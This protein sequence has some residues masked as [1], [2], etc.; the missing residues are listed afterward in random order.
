MDPAA[1]AFDPA[2]FLRGLDALHAGGDGPDAVERYLGDALAAAGDDPAARLQILNEAM[3]HHRAVSRHDDALREAAEALALVDRLGLAGTEAHATTLVNAATAHRAAGRQEEAL[4]LYADARAAAARAYPAGDRRLAAL[5]N[6]LALALGETGD[7]AGARDELAAALAILESA[8]VDPG[9]DLDIAAA[10]SNLAL[11]C[12]A[13]GLEDEAR[14]HTR[15]ALAIV[16]AGGHREDPHAAAMLA[17]HAQA[18]LLGGHPAEAVDLYAEA[19]AIVA[20]AYGEGSDAHAI[21]ADNLAAARRALAAAGP[22]ANGSPEAAPAAAS[23]PPEATPAALTGM[24]LARELWEDHVRPMLAERYP[25]HRGRIAA[26][27]VGHGSECYG[28]DDA[29][30][31][32]HDFGPGLC[33]WLT[34]AD[35]AEIGAALQADY[36]ALPA[37]LHGIG[38]RV[39]TARAQGAGRRVGVFEI[40]EFFISVAGRPEAPAA[41]SPHEWMMLEEATL[42]AATNGVVL[43]DPLGAF[44]AVRNGFRRMPEDVRLARIAQRVGMVAQA[45]QYNVPRM[46]DRGDGEAAWLAVAELERA[47]ASLVLLLNGPNAA[48]YLPYYK[49]RF[50]ALRR[51][52]ARPASRLPEVHRDLSE[53]L[54]LASAAC[55]GGAGFGEGG[56]GA[57]PARERLEAAIERMSARFVAELR[58]QGLSRSDATFLEHHRGEVQSRIR[59]PWLR[60][61]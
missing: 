53:I 39:A 18:C 22:A 21:T 24:D 23:S 34:A 12:L 51:L 37:V 54:R 28:F 31:R 55:L 33:L 36:D 41:N 6:N 11:E 26:G 14:S 10:R 44:S 56:S 4:A 9:T 59:D 17:S 25:A 15:A 3:G 1:A 58:A 60:A 57:G 61:L 30:S 19:L 8:S 20:R 43:S 2:A 5:R 46:L 45:G 16:R 13:L 38:P 52:A 35:H 40:G 47:A 48:G 50:A 7:H 49:W 29:L 32:D 27:L 42:A